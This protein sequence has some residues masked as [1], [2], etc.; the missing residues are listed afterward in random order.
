MVDLAGRVDPDL[1]TSAGRS[2]GAPGRRRR[3]LG[4]RRGGGRCC[5]DRP[6]CLH[7][8]MTPTGAGTLSATERCAVLARGGNR[9]RVLRV[10]RTNWHGN[11]EDE[12]RGDQKVSHRRL[13][14]SGHHQRNAARFP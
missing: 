4:R 13:L 3:G 6:S 5:R 12:D 8:T 1:T 2:I 10:T 11:T 14:T 9:V 7:A